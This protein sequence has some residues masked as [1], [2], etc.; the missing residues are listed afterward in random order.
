MKKT[1]AWAAAV[2]L[3]STGWNCFGQNKLDQLWDR[4]NTL[5]INGNYKGAIAAYDSII[6]EGYVSSKLYYNLGNAYFR[7]NEI[8]KAIVNYNKA[9][10]LA[11]A[12]RDIEYNLAVANS[13]TKDLSETVP[14][15]FLQRWFRAL[16]TALDSNT[17]AIVSLVALACVLACA[18]VYLLAEKHNFRRG[19]F[20]TGIVFCIM[21]ILS[22]IFA[23]MERHE[24]LHPSK[25]I[26]ILSAAPVKSS[27]DRTSKDIFILHEGTEVEIMTSYD[28]WTEIM[29]ANGNK[30][31]I[32]NSALEIVD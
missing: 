6:N 12:N 22:V 21:F 29:I 11:P 19:G 9:K 1:I 28:S 26:V 7:E 8:G 23:S 10:K 24:M 2:I 5:Y 20:Y 30:G 18:I 32:Q 15:F 13:Y 14:E 4:A 16:R 17:W 27:P 3:I 25:A 31:W